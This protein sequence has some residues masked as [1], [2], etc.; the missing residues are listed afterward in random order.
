[1]N[2]EMGGLP[3]KNGQMQVRTH[4]HYMETKF[5]YR[6]CAMIAAGTFTFKASGSAANSCSMRILK[7]QLF[8]GRAEEVR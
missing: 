6:A 5:T 7:S 1:L 4:L 2:I 3:R 8:G